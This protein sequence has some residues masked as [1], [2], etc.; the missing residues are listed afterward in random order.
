MYKWRGVELT[1]PWTLTMTAKLRAYSTMSGKAMAFGGSWG[2]FWGYGFGFCEWDLLVWDSELTGFSENGARKN[3]QSTRRFED[4]R[5]NDWY[6]VVTVWDLTVA[7]YPVGRWEVSSV[8]FEGCRLAS[9][10]SDAVT[11]CS[12]RAFRNYEA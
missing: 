8:L 1:G 11:A 5:Q 12:P 4:K 3:F 6:D 9:V 10:T 7:C 2:A